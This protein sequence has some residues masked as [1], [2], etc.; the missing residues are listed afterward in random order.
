MQFEAAWQCCQSIK[1][2]ILRDSDLLLIYL[3]TRRRE[4]HSI[5]I[6]LPAVSYHSLK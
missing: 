2:E 5:E 4:W 1:T 6:A 3:E